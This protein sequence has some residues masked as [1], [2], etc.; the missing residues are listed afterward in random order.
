MLFQQD[1]SRIQQVQLLEKRESAHSFLFGMQK[2]RFY[3]I[4]LIVPRT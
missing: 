3:S 4:R 1:K 2:T